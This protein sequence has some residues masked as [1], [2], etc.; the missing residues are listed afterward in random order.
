M[1]V[2]DRLDPLRLDKRDAQLWM[3]ALAMIVILASAVALLLYP[4]AFEENISISGP[5]MR[6]IFF[7]FCVLA[8]LMV[9]YLMDRRMAIRKLSQRLKEERGRNAQLLQQASLELLETLPKFEHFQDQLMMEFRRATIARQP[10]SVVVA[11]LT[12]GQPREEIGMISAYG[13]AAKSI[14]H[15]MRK[16]DSLYLFRTGVFGVLVPGTCAEDARA[17]GLRLSE[18]LKEAAGNERLFTFEL[19]VI[20]YPEDA[21]SAREIQ[22]AAANAFPRLPQLAQAA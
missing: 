9:G 16:D 6:S 11:A 3:L 5:K 14:L 10:L 12:P 21:A 17:V 8:C 19:K 20:N 22:N 7:S 2:F 15:R 18:G 13:A 4:S 1:Q